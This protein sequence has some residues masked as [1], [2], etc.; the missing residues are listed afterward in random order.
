MTGNEEALYPNAVDFERLPIVQQR[1]FVVDRH[2]RQ[3]I[4]MIDHLAANRPRQVTVFDFADVQPCVFE[5]PGTVRF[6]RAHMI[7]ILMGNEDMADR[8]RIDPHSGHFLS[9]PVV[10]VSRVDHDG[11]IAFAVKKILATHSRTQAT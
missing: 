11:R 6:H 5:K 10:V 3:L 8:F 1:L 4:E 9:Q 7:R 2:L